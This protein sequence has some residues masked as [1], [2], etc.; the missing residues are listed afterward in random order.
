[1]KVCHLQ[2]GSK[3]FSTTFTKNQEEGRAGHELWRK[4]WTHQLIWK[5]TVSCVQT[6]DWYVLWPLKFL[7][8]R[9]P[10]C[11]GTF[12]PI[13]T[14]GRKTY[15]HF[16]SFCLK[17]HMVSQI[18]HGPLLIRLIINSELKMM[19]ISMISTAFHSDLSPKLA[20]RLLIWLFLSGRNKCVLSLWSKL[21]VKVTPKRVF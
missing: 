12:P 18:S 9:D 5:L 13:M 17:Q 10:W 8:H 15:L 14:C 3:V 7:F 1:M 11:A 19:Q 2:K 4:T 16:I 20:D 21:V 6:F